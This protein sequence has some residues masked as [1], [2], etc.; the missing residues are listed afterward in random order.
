MSLD[1]AL[2]LSGKLLIA[3]P[4]MADPRFARS[5]IFICAHSNEETLGLVINKPAQGIAFSDLLEQL[6]IAH[7][8]AGPGPEVLIGGPVETGRGFVL[9]SS[10]YDCGAATLRVNDSFSMTGTLDVMEDIAQDRGPAR[11]MLMLGYAGWGGGQL[12]EELLANGWLTCEA[13]AEIVFSP[14]HATKWERALRSIGV[15]AVNLSARA[16]HA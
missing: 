11:A 14:D 16:G 12:A 7:G 2:D 1:D 15:D 5:L 3:M 8:S 13:S 10:D 6:S 4:G 9:H